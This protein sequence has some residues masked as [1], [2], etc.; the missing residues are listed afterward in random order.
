MW[1]QA[2]IAVLAP[3]FFV[4]VLLSCCALPELNRLLN[5][6]IDKKFRLPVYSAF[7]LLTLL[8]STHYCWQ[9]IQHSKAI[10]YLGSEQTPDQYLSQQIDVY[11]MIDYLNKNL[12]EDQ[13]YVYL[14][15]TGNNFYYHDKK[16]IAEGADSGRQLAAWLKASNNI[17]YLYEEL[18]TRGIGFLLMHNHKIEAKF[19]QF[20]D[21]DQRALWN[22]FSTKY[23]EPVHSIPPYSL[24]RIVDPPTSTSS[25]SRVA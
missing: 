4:L 10:D 23:L 19:N 2:R 14:L 16:V 21:A 25:I 8:F 22:A 18:A 17:D 1:E 3:V 6:L 5:K 15:Y 13:G 9:Y 11:P 12:P 24:W 7:G 20:L